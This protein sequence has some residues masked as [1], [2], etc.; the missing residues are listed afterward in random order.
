MNSKE[1]RAKYTKFLEGHERC[2]FQQSLEWSKVKNFWE[3]EVILAEDENGNIIGSL[4]V[5]LRKI[6]VFGY[7]MYS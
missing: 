5:L 6:P 3:N 7:L 1:D 2:N 4:S